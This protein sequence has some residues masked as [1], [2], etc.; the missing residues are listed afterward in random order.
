MKLWRRPRVWPISCSTTWVMNCSTFCFLVRL[1]EGGGVPLASAVVPS[2]KSSSPRK[3][4]SQYLHR[5]WSGIDFQESVSVLGC[6]CRLT[7]LLVVGALSSGQ[8]WSASST[9]KL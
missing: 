9:Q 8:Y 5:L 1:V 2:A 7:L 4:G 6:F 3:R